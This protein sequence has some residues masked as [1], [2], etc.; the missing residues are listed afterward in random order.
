MHSC[1]RDSN[2]RLRSAQKAKKTSQMADSRGSSS[3]V[4]ET[5]YY[6]SANSN[7]RLPDKNTTILAIYIEHVDV[8]TKVEGTFGRRDNQCKLADSSDMSAFIIAGHRLV[9]Q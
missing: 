3:L 8:Y 7:S 5:V 4:S 2:P 1:A 6:I 9:C